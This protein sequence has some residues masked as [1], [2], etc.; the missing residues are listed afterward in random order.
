MGGSG[1]FR[2]GRAFAAAF[3]L[4]AATGGAFAEAKR[5]VFVGDSMADGLW[6]GFLRLT[7]RDACLR[8]ELDLKRE[9]KIATGLTRADRFSWPEHVRRLGASL[10]PHLFVVS[11]GLNDRQSV[12]D[13]DGSRGEWG[14]PAWAAKYREQVLRVVKAGLAAGAEVVWI[15]LP[16]MRDGVTDADARDKNKLF[17]ETLADLGDPR[18]RYLDPWRLKEESDS[19]ASYGP[20]ITGSLV[21]IRNSDGIHFTPMGY[22]LVAAYLFPKIVASFEHMGLSFNRCGR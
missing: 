19:F 22:E 9:A 15:G 12:I 3:I 6:N 2:A 1:F 5:I 11:L 10:K 14:T 20:D 16:A 17:A 21:Q 18:A 8:E 13:V 4:L 7:I